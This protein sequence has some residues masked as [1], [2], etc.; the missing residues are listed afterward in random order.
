[1]C[2]IV[3]V[4]CSSLAAEQLGHLQTLRRLQLDSFAADSLLI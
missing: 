3:I 4:T 2:A 1:M